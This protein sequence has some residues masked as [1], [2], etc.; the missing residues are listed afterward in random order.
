MENIFFSGGKKNLIFFYTGWADLPTPG[1]SITSKYP[2]PNRVNGLGDLPW[3]GLWGR[4]KYF[5]WILGIRVLVHWPILMLRKSVKI[6]FILGLL[7]DPHT[8]AKRKVSRILKRLY[9]DQ[10]RYRIFNEY[11][12]IWLEFV[13]L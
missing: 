11:N 5:I 9:L 2:G 7:N 8:N 6:V 13:C 10:Y 12:H 1:S 4:N 3:V